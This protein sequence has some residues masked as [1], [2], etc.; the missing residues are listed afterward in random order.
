MIEI[1][2]TGVN[3]VMTPA[4]A[5]QYLQVSEASVRAMLRRGVLPGRKLGR[6]WRLLKV[7]LQERLS[8]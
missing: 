4:Q 2:K 1:D 7:D 5:A 6:L 8:G 3:E